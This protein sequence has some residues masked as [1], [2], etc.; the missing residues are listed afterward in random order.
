MNN[1][2]FIRNQREN[3]LG[4]IRRVES[5]F[6]AVYTPPQLHYSNKLLSAHNIDIQPIEKTPYEMV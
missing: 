1:A 2:T 5:N 4:A 6:H 3:V